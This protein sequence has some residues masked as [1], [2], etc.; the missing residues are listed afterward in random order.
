MGTANIGGQ[1]LN[2]LGQQDVAVVERNPAGQVLP[3]QNWGGTGGDYV[4][5][6]EYDHN[7]HVWVLGIFQETLTIGSYTLTSLG[8]N[9]VFILKLDAASGAVL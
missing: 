5:D 8:S 1:T 9:D 4:Y 3:V 2:F 7:G 6:M